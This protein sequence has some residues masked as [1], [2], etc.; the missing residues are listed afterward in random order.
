MVSLP[1][2][3]RQLT[4]ASKNLTRANADSLRSAYAGLQELEKKLLQ[5]LDVENWSRAATGEAGYKDVTDLVSAAREFLSRGQ[6]KKAEGAVAAALNKVERGHKALGPIGTFFR[7]IKNVRKR[8]VEMRP[9]DGE[10]AGE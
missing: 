4:A 6:I 2:I 7:W 8:R 5:G 9:A 1:S 3:Y 10:K